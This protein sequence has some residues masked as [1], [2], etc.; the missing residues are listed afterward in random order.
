MFGI[1]IETCPA[2]GGAVR[3]ISCIEDPYIIEK[4]LTHIWSALHCKRK[5]CCVVE[6]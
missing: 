3:I 4:I 1:D 2:R 5:I 6:G